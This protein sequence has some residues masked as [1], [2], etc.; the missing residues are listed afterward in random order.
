VLLFEDLHKDVSVFN[1]L[2]NSETSK[3]GETKDAWLVEVDMPGVPKD[4]VNVSVTGRYLDLTGER[5]T[6]EK[7]FLYRERFT[8]PDNIRTTE[9][10][11]ATLD[12]GVLMVTIPKNISSSQQIP[13]N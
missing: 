12:L 11:T 6:K 9:G 5:T 2:L 4:K 1:Y 10:I 3:I 13:V 8:L 7:P